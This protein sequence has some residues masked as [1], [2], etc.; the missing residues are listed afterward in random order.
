MTPPAGAGPDAAGSRG[1]AR[2]SYRQIL[3]SSTLVGGASLLQMLI[4]LV[5]TKA[6]AVWL[7]PAGLGLMSV[8]GTVVDLARN[9]ASLGLNSSGVR[10]IAQAASSG[11]AARIVR[12]AH[13]LRATAW[14][15]GC[16]GGLALAAASPWVSQLTFGT[17]ERA[18]EIALLGAALW[19]RLVADG[20]GALVHGLRRIAD[21]TR[22]DLLAAAVG[23]LLAIGLVYAWRE[24]GVAPALV[25]IAAF[26]ALT[27][28][29]VARQAMQPMAPGPASTASDAAAAESTPTGSTP[30]RAEL[31]A[32]ARVLLRGGLALMGSGLLT[33]GAAWAVRGVLVRHAG[34]AEA[35]L[36]QSAWALGGLLVGVVVQSMSADFYP[37]LVGVARD[38]T[39]ATRLVNEQMLV[40]LLV[41]GTGVL[42]TMT[43]AP[44]ALPLLYSRAFDGAQE[45]L[46]WVC[47]GMALRVVTWPM[48]TLLVAKGAQTRLLL[49]DLVWAFTWLGLAWAWVDTWGPAGAGMAFFAA[50][51]VQATLLVPMVRAQA[52]MRWTPANLRLGAGMAALIGGVFAAWQLLPA[53]WAV[54]LGLAGTLVAAGLTL[55]VLRAL[56]SPQALPPRLRGWLGAGTP[57]A[58]QEE[59]R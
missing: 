42:A 24:S 7:G 39:A 28:W 27:S 38:D 6:F 58:Q 52:G 26:S 2:H 59:R 15:L 43:L 47:L 22:A 40:N 16:L 35:G 53:P 51:A 14:V 31:I 36:F 4:G 1:A 18:T 34:L 19:L 55:H 5:R 17:T 56:V 57:A 8:F 45:A 25:A 32:E 9:L 3:R 41:G 29:W 44:V 10:R 49:A 37:R 23:S 33:L 12:T 11:E 46:R 21:M 30:T 48:G 54:G 20:Y 13:A 50:Y